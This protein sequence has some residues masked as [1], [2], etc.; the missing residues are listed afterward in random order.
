MVN[1]LMVRAPHL[2]LLVAV[3]LVTF[4]WEGRAI[5]EGFYRLP[6]DAYFVH[7]VKPFSLQALSEIWSTQWPWFAWRPVFLTYVSLSLATFGP[8]PHFFHAFSILIHAF[9]IYLLMLLVLRLCQH[10]P[11]RW[12]MA[13]ASGISFLLIPNKALAVF[14]MSCTSTL[15]ALFFSLLAIHSF[16]SWIRTRRTRFL[17]ISLPLY[18]VALG[19]K[20]EALAGLMAFP[21]LWWCLAN[22]RSRKDNLLWLSHFLGSLALTAIYLICQRN[23]Y[24]HSLGQ[25]PPYHNILSYQSF[26]RFINYLNLSSLGL[27]RLPVRELI[28][29]VMVCLGCT[30]KGSRPLRALGLLTMAFLLP[31]PLSGRNDYFTERFLYVPAA[32]VCGFVACYGLWLMKRSQLE[33]LA[34]GVTLAFW[35]Y[36]LTPRMPDE[37]KAT[38]M[39]GA[40]LVTFW[41]R[42]WKSLQEFWQAVKADPQTGFVLR[43]AVGI[44]IA[45]MVGYW[46]LQDIS[47]TSVI[48]LLATAGFLAYRK[49]NYYLTPLLV[50]PFLYRGEVALAGTALA[51][52]T[53][54]ATSDFH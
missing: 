26:L 4:A 32:F 47:H 16:I 10:H 29:L 48:V 39:A 22:P 25:Y 12:L 5:L 33:R 13:V 2:K 15:L 40:L 49:Q 43:L 42:G 17:V 1:R 19:S 30:I 34:G 46:V 7:T 14:W 53:R 45:T 21:V 8:D 31:L 50:I 9:N 11:W 44:L 36:L 41:A 6:D 35:C 28:P 23:I 18:F 27:I 24:F 38:L 37:V 20:E 54:P 3:L 52:L 51:L